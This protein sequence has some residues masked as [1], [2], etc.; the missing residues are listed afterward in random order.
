MIEKGE[1]VERS[2]EMFPVTIE[3]NEYDLVVKSVEKCTKSFQ[4]FDM[5][6]VGHSYMVAKWSILYQVKIVKNFTPSDV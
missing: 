2:I 1:S 6:D 5:S 3:N 4:R